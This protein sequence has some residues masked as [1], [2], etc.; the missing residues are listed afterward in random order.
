MLTAGMTAPASSETVPLKVAETDC[1][2]ATRRS[3][4][5]AAA[6]INTAQIMDILRGPFRQLGISVVNLLWKI[7]TAKGQR[8]FFEKLF[9]VSMIDPIRYFLGRAKRAP[10]IPGLN[11]RCL[12]LL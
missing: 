2:Q 5:N 3:P 1:A 12:F 7:L 4:P 10:E 6:I 9:L 8:S 11:G